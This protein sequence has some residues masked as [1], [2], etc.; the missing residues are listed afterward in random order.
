MPISGVVRFVPVANFSGAVPAVA[1]PAVGVS[2]PVTVVKVPAAGVVPPIAG[3]EAKKVLNPVPLTVEVAL[4]VV[5]AP[6]LAV[7]APTVPLMLI[8]AVPVR[9]VTVPL[10]GVPNAPPLTTNAPAVPVLTPSAV[11]TPVPVVMVAGA[12]PAPPPTTMALAAS[13]ADDAQSVAD[14]KYG[15]PPDV[16]AT[17]KASVPALV[18]GEPATEIRPPVNV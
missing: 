17:V 10:V 4:S 14:E 6:V 11:V 7:V 18:I 1:V 8:E 9:F 15:M 16:P 3:G 13:V 5:K 12:A 2:L